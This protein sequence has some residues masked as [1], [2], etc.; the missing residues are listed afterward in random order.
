MN[1][2]K[3]I[4]IRS[5]EASFAFYLTRWNYNQIMHTALYRNRYQSLDWNCV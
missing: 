3:F 4:Y 2:R 5:L 1:V